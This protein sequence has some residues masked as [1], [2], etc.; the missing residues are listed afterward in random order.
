MK[1]FFL[2][3]GCSFLTFLSIKAQSPF[4][5]SADSVLN[6]ISVDTLTD[7][8]FLKE[9]KDFKTSLKD[10]IE[11]K[12][13]KSFS[14]NVQFGFN[15]ESTRDEDVGLFNVYGG[16]NLKWDLYPG[17][18]DLNTH[19]GINFTNGEIQQNLSNIDISYDHM[20]TNLGDGLLLENYF[21]IKRSTDAYLGI[22]QRYEVGAGIIINHWFNRF[23]DPKNGTFPIGYGKKSDINTWNNLLQ[24][25]LSDVNFQ[26]FQSDFEEG[27]NKFKKSDSKLRLAL[28]TGAYFELEQ[29]S[30]NDSIDLKATNK[31]R[32]VIRPTIDIKLNEGW[33]FSL[34]PFIKMGM[35]WSWTETFTTEDGQT[36]SKTDYTIDFTAKISTQL[37]SQR[38]RIDLIYNLM[39]DNSPPRAFVNGDNGIELIVNNDLHQS[40]RISVNINLAQK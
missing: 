40:Y 36:S 23:V 7:S 21:Y 2:I 8:T 13:K 22:D 29:T 34:R 30:V 33:R 32:W 20:H 11:Y 5:T 39:F 14:G 10:A 4:L 17:E 38:I 18:L 37:L 1:C 16:I 19:F 6:V 3:L 12:D 24:P 26:G 31:F 27:Y 25:R 35:P 15:G 9:I 28:L